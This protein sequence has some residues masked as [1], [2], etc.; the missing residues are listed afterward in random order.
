MNGSSLKLQPL[1]LPLGSTL[2][3]VADKMILKRS[4]VSLTAQT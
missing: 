2:V 1:L 4:V 3:A